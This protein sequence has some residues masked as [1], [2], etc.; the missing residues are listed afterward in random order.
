MF[1]VGFSIESARSSFSKTLEV[2]LD[3]SLVELGGFDAEERELLSDG[4]VF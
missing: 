2:I 3:L 1:V 4:Q